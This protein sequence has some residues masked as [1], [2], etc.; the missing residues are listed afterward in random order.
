[1]NDC[2]CFAQDYTGLPTKD[3]TVKTT[4][5]YHDLK[6]KLSILFEYNLLMAYSMIWK[7]KIQVYSRMEL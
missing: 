7:R 6:F 1:M 4:Q 5:G 2:V 3:E